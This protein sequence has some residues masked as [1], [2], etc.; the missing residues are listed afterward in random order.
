MTHNYLFV[1]R[2]NIM[3]SPYAAKWLK[4]YCKEHGIDAKVRS[5]GLYA[6]HPFTT[7]LTKK[8]VE[9]ADTI[10]AM[11]EYIEQT[12]VDAYAPE[13]NKKIINLDIP[14]IFTH[15]IIDSQTPY[16]D[17][18]EPDQAVKIL[19]KGYENYGFTRHF[20]KKFFYKVLHAKLED[21]IKETS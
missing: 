12:I 9:W 1:C 21:I 5:A 18:A 8:D 7:Q 14:D 19:E 20:G 17:N 4:D 13:P 3:R 6:T 15:V 10:F 16:D 2:H 11:E